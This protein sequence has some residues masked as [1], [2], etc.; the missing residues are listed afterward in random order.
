MS[1]TKTKKKSSGRF[2]ESKRTPSDHRGSKTK[3]T[4]AGRFPEFKRTSTVQ[5][6]IDAMPAISFDTFMNRPPTK[7]G[8]KWYFSTPFTSKHANIHGFPKVQVAWFYNWFEGM[9][10]M[11]R[12]D[13]EEICV[14]EA[15]KL[16][17]KFV[18]IRQG[19]HNTETKYKNGYPAMD[20][21]TTSGKYEASRL[22]G[23]WH[24]TV[25]MGYSYHEIKLHGHIYIVWN[26]EEDSTIAE[27]TDPETQREYPYGW[28]KEATRFWGMQRLQ[29]GQTL[30][31]IA[32]TDEQ[33]Q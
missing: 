6:D 10:E 21:N 9:T 4:S 1:V 19:P 32:E 26:G 23:D 2:P 16:K 13:V 22:P 30:P 15:D 17:L 31:K 27:V 20:L 24:I 8:E 33:G 29:R 11:R 5:H 12:K 3:K 18:G 25:V 7:I 14:K 28:P